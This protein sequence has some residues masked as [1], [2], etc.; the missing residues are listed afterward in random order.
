MSRND[1]NPWP[2]EDTI[3]VSIAEVLRRGNATDVITRYGNRQG[4]DIEAHLPG[5]HPLI[6]ECKGEPPSERTFGPKQGQP[7][8]RGTQNLDRMVGFRDGLALLIERMTNPQ[9]V[10]AFGLPLTEGFCA[11]LTRRL[12]SPVR[13]VLGLHLFLVE[14]SNV[15]R[16]LSP[17]SDHPAVWASLPVLD[18]MKLSVKGAWR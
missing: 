10:Y 4:I 13:R 6:C 9:A 17:D 16:H 3:T 11:L 5:G 12:P 14:E 8:D 15:V 7:K 1:P 18:L 2:A